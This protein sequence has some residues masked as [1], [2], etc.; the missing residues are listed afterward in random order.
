MRHTPASKASF[1]LLGLCL[2]VGTAAPASAAEVWHRPLALGGPQPDTQAPALFADFPIT[3]RVNDADAH[4]NTL[5][6]WVGDFLRSNPG[7]AASL[8]QDEGLAELT[9]VLGAVGQMAGTDAWQTVGALLGRSGTVFLRPTVDGEPDMVAFSAPRDPIVAG[10]VLNTLQIFAGMGERSGG[11]RAYDHAGVRVFRLG[12]RLHQCSVDDLVV[13]ATS[14][15]LIEEAIGAA[16]RA[17]TTLTPAATTPG[18]AVRVGLDLGRLG[19]VLDALKAPAGNPFAEFMFGGWRAYAVSGGRMTMSL[20]PTPGGLRASVRASG[21]PDAPALEPFLDHSQGTAPFVRS[22]VPGLVGDVSLARDWA[23]LFAERETRLTPEGA[24][25]AAQFATTISTLL[26]G[27]GFADELLPEIDG[28]VRL[29][30]VER[31]WSAEAFRVSPT[32]PSFA[33]V[34]PLRSAASA[35]LPRRVESAAQGLMS[36]LA[37]EQMNQGGPPMRLDLD[38]HEGVRIV[39]SAFDPAALGAGEPGRPPVADLRYNFTPASAVVPTPGGS[40]VFVFAGSPSLVRTLI[41]AVRSPGPRADRTPG[42]KFVLDGPAITR[43]LMLN[44]EELIAGEMLKRDCDRAE[45]A[46]RIDTLVALVR[47]VGSVT[48]DSTVSSTGA[49]AELQVVLSQ[50]DPEGDRP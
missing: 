30:A 31:D 23:T 28:P 8:E 49:A 24:S 45:A 5:R 17:A 36:I 3:V 2:V 43:L 38:K 12:D 46:A 4:F 11:A 14:R 7:V 20:A 13:V 15:D 33:L 18:E 34:L 19:P 50:P 48:L 1:L 37:M 40:S 32:L 26:G 25:Q 39:Y 9:R 22:A 27:V 21:A 10:R 42:D 16:R 44:Y 29:V 47:L 6:S 35:D 41:S